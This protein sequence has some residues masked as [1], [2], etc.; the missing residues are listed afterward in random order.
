MHY[1]ATTDQYTVV[2]SEQYTVFVQCSVVIEIQRIVVM[3]Y[4][5]S[6]DQY[7]VVFSEQ[8]TVIYS[9]QYMFFLL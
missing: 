4:N 7:T 9:I 1:N 8:Y 5:A 6:T 3:H 2:F